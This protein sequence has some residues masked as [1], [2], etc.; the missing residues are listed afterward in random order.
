MPR[1]ATI[2]LGGRTY[3]VRRLTI[4]QLREIGIGT[5][6]AADLLAKSTAAERE[7]AAYDAMIATILAALARDTPGI[8][9]QS[10]L[11]IETDFAELRDAHRT[12]L[13]LAGLLPAGEAAAAPPDG[14]TSTAS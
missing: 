10:I 6:A 13:A 3:E 7:A 4:G 2:N 8:T 5:T 9:A 11:E 14:A 12:V 1:T